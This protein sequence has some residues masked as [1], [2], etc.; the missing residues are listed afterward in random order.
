MNKNSYPISFIVDPNGK[1]THA[2]VPI[3]LYEEFKNLQKIFTNTESESFE[4][5]E[6][7]YLS[8]KGINATGYPVGIRS[9]P[10]FMLLK[11]S[12][13][14]LNCASSLRQPVIALKEQLIQEGI[15]VLDPQRNCYVVTEGYLFSSPSFAASLVAGNNR[16]GLDIWSNK[17]GFTLKQSGYG[18]VANTTN[19]NSDEN[20]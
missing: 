10:R 2:V 14:S 8:L 15:L 19:N 18:P 20:K 4:Q 11:D 3:D 12:L 6:L 16:N 5:K 1:K 9:V 17:D 7:Y 13:V